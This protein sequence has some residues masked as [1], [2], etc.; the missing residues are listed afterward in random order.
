MLDI[1][2]KSDLSREKQISL[3]KEIAQDGTDREKE[4][5]SQILVSAGELEGEPS[6]KPDLMETIRN[7][8]FAKQPVSG[9]PRVV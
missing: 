6:Q 3:L 9:I 5:A 4:R 2:F 8:K 1:G 7:W